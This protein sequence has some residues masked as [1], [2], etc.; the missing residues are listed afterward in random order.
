M[1]SN[2]AK[3]MLKLLYWIAPL[4]TNTAGIVFTDA[5]VYILISADFDKSNIGDRIVSHSAIVSF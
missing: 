3:T 4:K 5:Q 2:H 1:V